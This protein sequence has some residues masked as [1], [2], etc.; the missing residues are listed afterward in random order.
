MLKFKG[1]IAMKKMGIVALMS[2]ALCCFAVAADE[3]T[4]TNLQPTQNVNACFRLFPTNNIWTFLKL[5][6]RTG[7][8]WQVQFGVEG[9]TDRF[10]V[11]VNDVQLASDTS[12]EGRFTLYPTRNMFNFL[13][14]DQATGQM[15]QS[16]WSQ[17]PKERGIWSIPQG[18]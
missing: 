15:W 6:T 7:L 3:V 8:V 1:E 16:Q 13:L 11:V 18:K 5:D 17:T 10:T 2:L 9:P 14:I 12:K 4:V